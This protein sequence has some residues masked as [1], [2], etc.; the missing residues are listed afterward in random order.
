MFADGTNDF[1]AVSF[2][3]EGIGQPKDEIS[4]ETER[5]ICLGNEILLSIIVGE[6]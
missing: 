6:D 2:R 3:A 1:H 4:A 5:I